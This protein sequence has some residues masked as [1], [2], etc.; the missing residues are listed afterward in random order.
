MT[1]ST[2]MIAAPNEARSWRS[3]IQRLI[4]GSLAQR[5]VIGVILLNGVIL[6][7]ETSGHAMSVAGEAL[8]LLDRICLAVFVVE[9]ALKLVAWGPRFF[10]NGWNLFDFAVVGISLLPATGDLSILR[11]LRVL[12]VLRLVSVVPDMRRIVQA[13]LQAIPGMASIAA[14]LALVYYVFGVMAT[15]LF[16]ETFPEWFGTIGQSVFS[17]FQVMTLDAWS[18]GLVRPMLEVHPHAWLFFVPFILV[19]SFAVLNLFIAIIVNSM[20]RM[21]EEEQAAARALDATVHV[22]GAHVAGELASLRAEIGALRRL[23]EQK[24]GA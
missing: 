6:G 9:L 15:R 16:G 18:D 17:L 11:A 24:V 2:R 7:L 12:R 13:L 8:I 23:L 21:H 22:E 5:L 19:T 10:R 3:G 4:E 14:L 20:Q 1:D